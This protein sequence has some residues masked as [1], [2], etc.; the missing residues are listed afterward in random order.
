MPSLVRAVGNKSHTTSVSKNPAE[1]EIPF[2][3]AGVAPASADDQRAESGFGEDA[4]VEVVRES[5][6]VRKAIHFCEFVGA[7]DIDFFAEEW[8]QGEEVVQIAQPDEVI[9]IT[10]E[11]VG[12]VSAEAERSSEK[13]LRDGADVAGAEGGAALQGD[14]D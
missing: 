11:F 1:L 10:V 5:T 8:R 9:L 6:L 4:A 12:T 7:D 3:V 2:A 14:K 13:E